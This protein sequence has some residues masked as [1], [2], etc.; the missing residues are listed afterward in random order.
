MHACLELHY[1]NIFLYFIFWASEMQ[2]EATETSRESPDFPV[3]GTAEEYARAFYEVLRF[4][5]LKKTRA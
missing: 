3:F 5:T 2:L 4:S 1:F